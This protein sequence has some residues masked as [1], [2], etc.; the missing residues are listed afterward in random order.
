MS[1]L[2]CILKMCC[3]TL[4]KLCIIDIL[5]ISNS[6]QLHYTTT[7]TTTIGYIDSKKQSIL[8]NKSN[9]KRIKQHEQKK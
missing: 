9:A 7:T 2:K 8:Q 3:L 1:N 6:K 4:I 5:F